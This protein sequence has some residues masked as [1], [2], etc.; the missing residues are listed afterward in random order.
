MDYQVMRK[1][2]TAV[3]MLLATMGVHAQ[4]DPEY[5]MEIGAAAGYVNYLGDF[6]GSLTK[7]LQPSLSILARYNFNP[8]MGLKL[9]ATFSKLKGSSEDVE[10]YYPDY[11]GTPYEF[12]RTM[13]DVS[14]T[15]E[16]NFWP[17]GTGRDYRGAKRLT[18]YV[19]GGLG[20]S[21]ASGG[22]E[23]SAFTANLPIGLGLKYKIGDRLNV[24]LEWA[25]HFSLSDKL[26]GVEDPYY[27][28]SSGMFKNTDCYSA[29]QLSVSYSFMAKCRTCN[30][31]EDY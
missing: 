31:D 19:F 13:A 25:I 28:K 1:A 26:D 11:A 8:Y 4:D 10:T 7:D 30:R 27:V 24:G 20:A 21:Y 29:L 17:Y 12:S 6:N 9:D 16:Y 18:P 2:L 15:Y 5:R 14:L 23:K 3:L 22:D